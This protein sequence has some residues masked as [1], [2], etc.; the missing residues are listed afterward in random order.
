MDDILFPLLPSVGQWWQ[1]RRLRYNV[2]LA[3]A[4][5]VAF[6]FYVIFGELLVLDFEITLFTIGFQAIGYLFMM[7]IANMFYFLGPMIDKFFNKQNKPGFRS[8][9]FLAGCIF[10][11]ALPFSIP[12]LIIILYAG[13]K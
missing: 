7:L 1:K 8:T 5:I 9:L 12:I 11:C 10:S 6:I 13:K 2:S 4:G 3:T